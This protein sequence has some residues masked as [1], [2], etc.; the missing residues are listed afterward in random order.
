MQPQNNQTIDAATASVRVKPSRRMTTPRPTAN[1]PLFH[2][3][4]P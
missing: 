4:R 1:M 3:W 2:A